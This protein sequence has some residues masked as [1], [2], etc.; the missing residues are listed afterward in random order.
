MVQ[1]LCGH[2]IGRELHEDPQI[3]NYGKRRAGSEIK[4]G[5]VFCL[6]PMAAIGDASIK[7]KRKWPNF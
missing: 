7:K 3:L 4:E 6:E 2:G 5:M 1:D